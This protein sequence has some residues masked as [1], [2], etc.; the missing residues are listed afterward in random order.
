VLKYKAN[1]MCEDPTPRLATA[2]FEFARWLVLHFARG[3][4]FFNL[5]RGL[6][7][8]NLARALVLESCQGLWFKFCQGAGFEFCQ[9]AGSEFCQGASFELCQG[10]GQTF[11]FLL[12]LSGGGWW[13]RGQADEG[14]QPMQA[15]SFYSPPAL[16]SPP[17]K[18]SFQLVSVVV[19][20]S[21]VVDIH[22]HIQINSI[23][24]CNICIINTV[25]YCTV[26]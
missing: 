14:L 3:L 22:N 26:L 17:F 13:G 19:M 21:N 8:F 1:I 7:L 15:I 25:Q 16:S 4:V 9:G 23:L 24:R 18:T 10:A 5:A 12:C 6:V 20:S 2:K 11:S